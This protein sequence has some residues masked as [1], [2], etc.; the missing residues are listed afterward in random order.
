[1]LWEWD[2]ICAKFRGT[3]TLLFDFFQPSDFWFSF[4]ESKPLTG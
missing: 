4:G 2:A 3:V 1:M